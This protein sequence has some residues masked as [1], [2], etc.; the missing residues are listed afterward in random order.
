MRYGIVSDIHSNR[1]ALDAVLAAMQAERLDRWLCCGDLV[2]YA[3]E[4]AACVQAVRAAAHAVVAGNHDWA[5][6]GTLSTDRFH[7][8]AAAAVRWTAAHLSPADRAYL[9]G[10]PLTWS[11]DQVTLAHGT[12]HHPD[13]FDYLLDEDRAAQSF[14]V[15]ATPVA[16]VGHTHVPVIYACGPDGDI[17]LLHDRAVALQPGVRY[18]VNVG[19]VGQPRDHDAQAAYAVYDTDARRLELTRVPYPIA[20]AQEKIRAAGLPDRCADRLGRGI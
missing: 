10:L 7:P 19:S 11:D 15:Q 3:A 14:M 16:F 8:E 6:A 17:R 4:P 13:A 5:V 1:D 2:G 20:R 18:L 12:L 9:A